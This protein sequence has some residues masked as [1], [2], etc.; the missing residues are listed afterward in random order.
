[1]SS[2]K[3]NKTTTLEQKNN[4]NNRGMS[5]VWRFIKNN[6][7]YESH[8]SVKMETITVIFNFV[9]MAERKG[10]ERN[11]ILLYLTFFM[12]FLFD[13]DVFYLPANWLLLGWL[14]ST[15]LALL[16]SALLCL[17]LAFVL[18]YLFC[19]MYKRGWRS[20]SSYEENYWHIITCIMWQVNNE[21]LLSVI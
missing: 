15:W 5:L 17:C 1:M 9:I 2:Q 20:S 7:S 18:R 11:E 6:D 4:N 16:D 12:A 3:R 10:M 8:K 14:D 19:W 21:R 13:V